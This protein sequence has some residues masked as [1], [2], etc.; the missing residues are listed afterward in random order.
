MTTTLGIIVPRLPNWLQRLVIRCMSE[1][2]IRRE[3]RDS[4]RRIA[5]IDRMIQRGEIDT[6]D[7]EEVFLARAAGI[8]VQE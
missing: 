1:D 8:K 6:D 4:E 5:I 2:R 3:L 7:P